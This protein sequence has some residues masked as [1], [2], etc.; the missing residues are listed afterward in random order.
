LVVYV[1]ID[2]VSRG[3]DIGKFVHSLEEVMIHTLR[4]QG[5]AADRDP[6][7]IGVWVNGD[8]LRS[9]GIAIRQGITFHGFA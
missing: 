7:N 9:I 2:L 1:L 4:D 8:K 5:I 3:F 6:R